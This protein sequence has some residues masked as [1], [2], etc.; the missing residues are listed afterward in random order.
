MCPDLSLFSGVVKDVV[1]SSHFG[2]DCA[3]GKTVGK[4]GEKYLQLLA[5]Q[6]SQ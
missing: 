3:K 1:D 6:A 5:K 4:C 2:Q